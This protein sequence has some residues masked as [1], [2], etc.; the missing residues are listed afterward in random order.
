[1]LTNGNGY[2][3]G[4]GKSPYGAHA[5][6]THDSEYEKKNASL[7]KATK[8]TIE[9]ADWEEGSASVAL[10]EGCSAY[11]NYVVDNGSA[12]VATTAELVLSEVGEATLIFGVTNVPE[13]P[14]DVYV[15]FL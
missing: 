9:V 14:I 6:H 1:M 3:D 13:D 10:P 5:D 8:I 11:V 12:S 15:M 2:L 4:N 7:L